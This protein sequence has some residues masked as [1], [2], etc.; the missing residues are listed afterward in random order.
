MN[1][2]NLER[3]LIEKLK[4]I[5]GKKNFMWRI[6]SNAKAVSNTMNIEKVSSFK[7]WDLLTLVAYKNTVHDFRLYLMEN[8]EIVGAIA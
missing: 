7:G 3:I 5:F 4:K 8:A 6:Q 1:E 2:N